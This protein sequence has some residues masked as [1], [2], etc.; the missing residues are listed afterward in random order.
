M[1]KRASFMN[2]ST[3]KIATYVKQVRKQH[4]HNLDTLI[5][6]M[7]N[8]LGQGTMDYLKPQ[9]HLVTGSACKQDSEQARPIKAD[10]I[11]MDTITRTGIP[12]FIM[13]NTAE[14]I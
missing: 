6:E 2:S 7:T 13:G 9:I 4:K 3:D 8:R 1:R 12:G 10:L 5:N 11:I 14:E